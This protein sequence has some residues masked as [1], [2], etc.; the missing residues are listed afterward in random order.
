MQQRAKT[1]PSPR[2]L[3]E[4]LA[5]AFRSPGAVIFSSSDS[6]G[7]Q[8]LQL[9]V[10]A[11]SRCLEKARLAAERMFVRPTDLWVTGPL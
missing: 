9:V 1:R 6:N 5:T 2:T 4:W 8:I 11:S 3:P 10:R 7:L